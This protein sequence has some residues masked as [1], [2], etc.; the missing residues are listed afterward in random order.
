MAIGEKRLTLEEFLALPEE[1]PPLEYADGVVTQ[2]VSPKTKHSALQFELA[3]RINRVAR[4]RQVARAFPELR[5]TFAG[6]SR[7]P[8]LSVFR[9][10]RIPRDAGG[11]LADGVLEP[12]DI[13]VEIVSPEQRVS[14]L[15]RRCLWY[16]AN[17]VQVA[18]LVDSEDRSI[19]AFRPGD[20]VRALHGADRIDL[21]EILPDF[22]LTVNELFSALQ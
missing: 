5:V 14:S 10:D 20:R 22:E 1:E 21:V 2:K 3:E 17:G 15:I 16:V 9:W 11:Q 12:P 19:L 4:P 8:D 18:L 6:K 7:V 13:A